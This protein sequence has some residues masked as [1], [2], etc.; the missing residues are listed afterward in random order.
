[1]AERPRS[2][3]ALPSRRELAACAAGLLLL[4]ALVFGSHVVHGGFYWDDWENAATTRYEYQAG[5]LGP[6][7]L[8]QFLYQPGLALL[9]PIPHALL[10]L[11]PSLHLALGLLLAVL[12]SLSLFA[13]LRTGGMERPYAGAIAA[14]VLVFPWSDSTRLWATASI[15][16]VAVS[17]CLLGAVL[18]MRGLTAQ[19]RR[20]RRLTAG[21]V[22]LYV[23]SVLTYSVAAVFAL[24][25]L[26]AYARVVPLRDALR[27]W[28]TDVVAILAALVFVGLLT[29][30]GVQTLSGQLHHLGT[31]LHQ[32]G[33]L[34]A[35]ALAPFGSPPRGAVG[36][37]AAALVALAAIAAWRLP[38]ADP[39]RAE[40]RR[41][42]V[43][44][45]G[46]LL[47]LAAG[48]ALFVPGDPKYVPLA[49][50]I[51]NR[52]NI[53]AA[54]GFAVLVQALAALATTLVLRGPR[55]HAARVAA[56]LALS[57]VVAIGWIR[58]THDHQRA[59]ARAA[60][61]QDRVL[62]RIE[63]A[64]AGVPRGGTI[65]TFG[66]PIQAA[67]GVPVFAQSWDLDA[68][69]KLTLHDPGVVAYPVRPTATVRCRP[70]SVAIH[71]YRFGKALPRS[72]KRL[73]FLDVRDGRLRR[74]PD[75]AA[76][77][78]AARDM[79]APVRGN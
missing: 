15:N 60:V 42:L 79:G 28:R 45:A 8:R 3:P 5:F 52:V 51:Y 2:A 23:A 71:D 22:A 77:A 38:A 32:S 73:V 10:G 34:F 47:A 55:L 68:A 49:P 46:A 21:S 18:G 59:W 75:P 64:R 24:L 78:V 53:V 74:I 36:A 27:R 26:L 17:L 9:L 20:A 41:W 58:V 48:Y 44:V 40:L 65:Y 29:T 61:L 7:D 19:G 4:A 16:N 11:H 6:L 56:A 12:M 57:A 31:M 72:Y 35:M 39:A 69:A 66:S 62:D 30:K 14:L 1:L 76:C 43:V 50:G 37:A 67:A 33:T 70:G 25:S 13:L 54:I 63:Q